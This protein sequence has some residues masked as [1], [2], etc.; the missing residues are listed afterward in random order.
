[1]VSMAS[2][3]C[4]EAAPARI[5]AATQM[6][7]MSSCSVAPAFSADCVP[8]NAIRTLG[9]VRH[10][11]RDQLLGL[12]RQCAVGKDAGAEGLEGVQR[13]GREFTAFARDLDACLAVHGFVHGL[14]L[15]G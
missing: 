7:S 5:S 2:V 11:H 9:H 14:F 13:L 4:A 8:T 10:S 12:A 1:M 3:E 15:Q 6:A